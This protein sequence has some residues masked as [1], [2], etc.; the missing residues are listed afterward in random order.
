MLA[1]G[2]K[3]ESVNFRHSEAELKGECGEK[4]VARIEKLWA[5]LVGGMRPKNPRADHAE[6]KE[7]VNEPDEHTVGFGRK[8][9]SGHADVLCHAEPGFL[10][11]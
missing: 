7:C 11:R 2:A 10:I 8:R 3:D 5:I 6:S 9:P 1:V 4:R